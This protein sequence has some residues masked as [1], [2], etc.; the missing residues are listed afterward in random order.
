[1]IKNRIMENAN[2][3]T[4]YVWAVTFTEN[5][6]ANQLSGIILPNFR[7]YQLNT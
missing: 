1:M 2:P 5:S 6:S 4:A 3:N 7:R